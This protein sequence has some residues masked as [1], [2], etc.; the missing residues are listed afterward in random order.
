MSASHPIKKKPVQRGGAVQSTA[1]LARHLGVSRWTISQV[2]NGH[3][4]V[5]EETKLRVREMMRQLRFSPNPWARGLRGSKTSLVG[6]CVPGLGTPVQAQKVMALQKL[7]RDHGY[8]TLIEVADK[9]AIEEQ[10]IRHFTAMRVEGVILFTSRDISEVSMEILRNQA[11]P[12][13]II[14]EAKVSGFSHV[15]VD[16]QVAMELLMSHLWDLGHRKFAFLG[17]SESR[18]AFLEKP[19]QDRS[20]VLDR[21]YV[22][23]DQGRWD[24]PGSD[25]GRVAAEQFLDSRFPATGLVAHNDLVALGAIHRLREAG[26]QIPRDVS[27]VGFDN[28]EVSAHY[29]PP[30]TTIDQSVESVMKIAIELLLTHMQE[31]V[32]VKGVLVPPALIKR[33]STGPVKGL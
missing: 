29:E 26:I 20:L 15:S 3:S 16:R 18:L 25:Y 2:L 11:L 19:L 9:P 4:G 21:D 13:I 12:A 14:D 24:N 7:L 32:P 6:V 8:R 23:F 33:Q 5:G 31:V 22:I 17:M 10:A 30:L 1:A 27:M 28:L